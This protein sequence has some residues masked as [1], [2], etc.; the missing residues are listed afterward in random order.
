MT[1]GPATDRPVVSPPSPRPPRTR[2]RS[3][4]DALLAWGFLGPSVVVFALFLVYPLGRT[5]YLSMH[6][7]DII[8]RPN[9]FVGLSHFAEM[10]SPEYV[11][12]LVTTLLFTVGVVL[13]GVAGALVIV[14][15]LEGVLRGQKFLRGAFALPFAFSVASAS[16]IFAVFYSPGNSVLN[17][18]LYRLGLDQVPWLT[19]QEMALWSIVIT[20]VWMNLGYGVLVLAAGIGS[21]P[22]EINEAARIDGATGPRLAW[23]VTVPMLGPQLFFLIVISTINALQSFGQIHILTGGGPVGSTTTL[24]YSVYQDAFAYG[25]SDFGRASAQALVLLLVVLVCT[26]VQ[27]G[28]IERKVHY[29]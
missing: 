6:G 25:T 15:L 3:G 26:V 19:S 1:T 8:G 23:D 24:V 29:S 20:T 14:L 16:V 11:Q 4:R 13:P 21:I 9:R 12:V 7:N 28:V 27:F 18:I 5:V 2:A 22:K 10:A 17:G